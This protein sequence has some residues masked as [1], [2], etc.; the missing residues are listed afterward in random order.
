MSRDVGRREFWSAWGCAVGFIGGA[1][2]ALPLGLWWASSPAGFAWDDGRLWLPCLAGAALGMEVG[3][4]VVHSLTA[5][6]SD[7][8]PIAWSGLKWAAGGY[9]LGLIAGVPFWWLTGGFLAPAFMLIYLTVKFA[10]AGLTHGLTA[11]PLVEK[12]LQ[13]DLRQHLSSLEA[14]RAALEADVERRFGPLDDARRAAIQGW[15]ADR[16]AAARRKLDDARTLEELDA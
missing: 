14:E 12:K 4:A 7:W 15:D 10:G 3:R 6:R 8:R 2:L 11:A 9:L 1:L 13:D 5:I 16:L